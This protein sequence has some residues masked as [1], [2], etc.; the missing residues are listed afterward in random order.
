MTSTVRKWAK[1]HPGALFSVL[2]CNVYI[3]SKMSYVLQCLELPADMDNSLRRI[4]AKLF[5]GIG[6]WITPQFL[7]N[8]KSIG[9]SAEIMNHKLYLERSTPELF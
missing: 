7:Y 2:A 3:L 1:L 4:C 9:A 8:M 5:P 6:M